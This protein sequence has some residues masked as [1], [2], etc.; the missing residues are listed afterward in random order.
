MKRF[1]LNLASLAVV[2]GL[3]F[4]LALIPVRAFMQPW[5]IPFQYNLPDFPPDV[6]GMRAAERLRLGL[7]GMDSVAGSR[8][9][10]VLAEARFE[11]GQP[12][13]NAREISHMQDVRGVIDWMFP[14]HTAV[15]LAWLALTAAMAINRGT[16]RRVGTAL[17][18]G[19]VVTVI[20]VAVLAVFGVVA[21]DVFFTAFHRIFFH[22][23]TWLFLT[24]DTLIRLYPEVFWF[25]ITLMIGAITVLLAALLVIAGL[26]LRSSGKPRAANAP[27]RRYPA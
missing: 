7:I 14:L 15:T 8:G 22:G 23:D 6:F 11:D 2:A 3:P 1:L 5:V 4:V 13:F 21:W 17:L 12:A 9:V 27:A 20:G 10:Q 18:A 19:V 25:R 16:R 24:T 26:A